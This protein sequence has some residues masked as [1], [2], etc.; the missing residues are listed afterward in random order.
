MT[1]PLH[2]YRILIADSDQQLARV[3][4]EILN[5]MGFA[6]IQLTANG[7]EALRLVNRAPFDF[8][9]TEW[10][11][12]E[13]NGVSLLDRIRRDGTSLN[14][15]LPVI[16]LTGRAEAA[17]V[18][19][20]RDHGINEYVVKPFSSKT[21]YSRLER[22]VEQ[23]RH[24]IVTDQFIGPDRR[25]KG[26]PPEGVAERRIRQPAPQL[27]PRDATGQLKAGELPKIWLPEYSLKRKLGNGVSLTSLI[28]P[29]VLSQAQ[30]AIDSIRNDSLQWIRD[31]LAEMKF[32][33]K[34]MAHEKNPAFLISELGEVALTIN[35]R[36]GTFGYT[37]ASEVAY[38]LYLFCR[39]QFQPQNLL[40]QTVAQKHIEVLQV[41]LSN[42]AKGLETPGISEIIAALQSLA[43]K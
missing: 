43:N 21:L 23:P 42:H 5:K 11:L 34:A 32:L 38:M 20:A 36:A 39:N 17:D 41:I 35:S 12:P 33:S 31:N 26:K 19:T 7:M 2:N 24:F 9:I 25:H 37:Q 40:H 29:E 15:T 8:L 6:H 14:P 28:T 1:N 3:L 22:L 27:R 18:A 4:K 30:T 16:M 10:H 13:L